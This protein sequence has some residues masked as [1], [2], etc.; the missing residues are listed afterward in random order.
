[1]GRSKHKKH[2]RHDDDDDDVSSQD[3]ERSL[4]SMGGAE[5]SS[6][7]KLIL[8]VGSGSSKHHGDKHKKKK[9]KKDRKKEK[10]KHHHKD[11]SLRHAAEDL[12]RNPSSELKDEVVLTTPSRVVDTGAQAQR[13][14]IDLVRCRC[15][16]TFLP[17]GL[18]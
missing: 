10:H 2:H 4:S 13:P 8:K 1:M 9:K 18:M 14:S 5:G 12:V 7:L 16:T 17:F 6:R 3:G 15:Y 11:K